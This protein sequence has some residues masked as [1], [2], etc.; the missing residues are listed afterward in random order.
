M[1]QPLDVQ[2]TPKSAGFGAPRGSWVQRRRSRGAAFAEAVILI[3][4]MII[5]FAGVRYLARYFDSKQKALLTARRC[6][7]I[8]S[9]NACLLEGGEYPIPPIC[10]PVLR[11]RTEDVHN[12]A[13]RESIDP[14]AGNADQTS[15]TTPARNL[16]AGVN[17]SLHPML[18]MLVG[19]S[20]TAVA[21]EEIPVPH[22]LLNAQSSIATSYYLPCNLAAQTPM[23]AAAK[24]FKDLG[25]DIP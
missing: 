10:L 15:D 23:Q 8:F 21:S 3:F 4:F 5:V 12:T 25:L 20:L 17:E 6:A 1:K 22:A 18:E 2:T 11:D 13:L 14:Q 16:R 7:W 19:Q 9:K 24:L